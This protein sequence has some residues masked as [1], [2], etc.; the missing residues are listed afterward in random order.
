MRWRHLLPIGSPRL[1]GRLG[2]EDGVPATLSY[3]CHEIRCVENQRP[4]WPPVRYLQTWYGQQA[5]QAQQNTFSTHCRPSEAGAGVCYPCKSGK[6]P[7]ARGN[8]GSVGDQES[9]L[10]PVPLRVLG[11]EMNDHALGILRHHR[12]KTAQCDVGPHRSSWCVDAAAPA[13]FAR[14]PAPATFRLAPGLGSGLGGGG[15]GLRNGGGPGR[16]GGGTY[17]GA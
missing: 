6:R 10:N 16:V 7:D 8:V 15:G 4:M 17:L 11:L 1:Y 9:V 3:R 13:A 14:L 12:P 5:D 2:L